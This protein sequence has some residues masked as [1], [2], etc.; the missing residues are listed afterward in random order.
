MTML[1]PRKIVRWLDIQAGLQELASSGLRRT[2]CPLGN[3][4]C[5]INWAHGSMQLQ[6]SCAHV[7]LPV[8]LIPKQGLGRS[9]KKTGTSLGPAGYCIAE[10]G[11]TLLDIR[12]SGAIVLLNGKSLWN[13]RLQTWQ[14]SKSQGRTLGPDL[15]LWSLIFN[16][17]VVSPYTWNSIRWALVVTCSLRFCCLWFGNFPDY[18][19]YQDGHEKWLIGRCFRSPVNLT[20]THSQC[21][22][23]W[24]KTIQ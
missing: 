7:G 6:D 10:F 8:L 4:W 22:M 20:W 16:Q 21:A 17:E 14:R 2:Q 23:P 11:C 24:L 13:L 5:V 1:R 9:P 3:C 12:G 19:K 15:V 18:S